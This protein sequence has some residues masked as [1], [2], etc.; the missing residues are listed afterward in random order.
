M[1][2]I[3]VSDDAIAQV[4]ARGGGSARDTLSALELVANTGTG[5]RR[6]PLDE[7][8]EAMIDRDPA[9]ALTMVARC[10]LAR[11]RPA[12]AHRG[13]HRPTC[14]TGSSP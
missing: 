6:R 14:A 11:I 3:D 9:A 13:A 1:P 4:L 5:H 12:H 8:V 7:Y 2:G 10:D